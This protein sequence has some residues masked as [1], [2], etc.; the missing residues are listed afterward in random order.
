MG[1]EHEICECLYCKD[2][3]DFTIDSHL[4]GEIQS[5]NVAI[6]AGA[7]ISTENPN[8]APHSL[9]TEMA[10]GCEIQNCDLAFPDLA[11]KYTDRPDGRFELLKLIQKR[12]DYINKFSELRHAATK[13]FEELSTMPYFRTFITTNWDRYFEDLCRA[14]PFVTD[15]DMSFWDIPYRRVLK[16]H[17]TIDD[18]SSLVATR[19]DYEERSEKLKSSLIGGKLKDILNTQTCI[20][21]GY[22][23]T[24]DDFKEIFEFVRNRQGPFQKTHYFVSP[25][26][27]DD[28][29]YPNIVPIKT[30]GTYFLSIIKQ[31]LCSSGCYLGDEIYESILDELLEVKEVQA[32]LWES[33]DV[34]KYPQMLMSAFYQDGLIH[35]YQLV[36]DTQ[37]EGQ[38]SDL[39]YLLSKAHRYE[40]RISQYRS[41]RKYLD[42][43]YF[44][45]FQNVTLAMLQSAQSDSHPYPLMYYYPQ[46]GEMDLDEFK[47]K[48]SGLP[49]VHKA[50]F[51]QCQKAIVGIPEDG[52][53][54]VHHQPW[55]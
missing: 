48:L 12:F 51:K 33:F 55:G 28:A 13:F 30:D 25:N 32:E 41:N 49:N 4:L 52:S 9:Y 15:P 22:S 50:A 31:H 24:D 18:Y 29:P 43:A 45:G 38:H 47:E 46:I 7:G 1:V 8:S 17:G 21:I 5:N 36:L 2:N 23:M 27:T 39:H 20:F 26:I 37:N 54:Q 40:G 10:V 14:K 53:M 42:V 19:K 3:N 34:H 16:I 44:Q 6:F 35:G 11:Q